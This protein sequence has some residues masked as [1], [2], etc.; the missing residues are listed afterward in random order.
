MLPRHTTKS[1]RSPR[2]NKWPCGPQKCHD[3]QQ[4]HD[5]PD[6]KWHDSF[7]IDQKSMNIYNSKIKSRWTSIVQKERNRSISALSKLGPSHG[8]FQS[9][10]PHVVKPCLGATWR[11]A[12]GSSHRWNQIWR[13]NMKQRKW[14]KTLSGFFFL[15]FCR[16]PKGEID[17]R[18]SV[19]RVTQDETQRRN[20]PKNWDTLQ[21]SAGLLNLNP[22]ETSCD[23][24]CSLEVVK[25]CRNRLQGTKDG[26]TVPWYM[27]YWCIWC[28]WCKWCIWCIYGL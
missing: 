28:I 10:D 7:K 2:L 1:R 23:I 20:A 11:F 3:S 17:V 19:C 13:K 6:Q 22:S 9:L 27:V 24:N 5:V 21:L 8:Q 14:L 15:S 12:L 26:R 25:T 16:P 4:F 18:W